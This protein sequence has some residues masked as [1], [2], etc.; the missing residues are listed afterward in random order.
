MLDRVVI[1]NSFLAALFLPDEDHAHATPLIER[2]GIIIELHAPQ[3]FLIEFSNLLT[4]CSRRKRIDQEELES[5]QR[6]AT[7]LPIQFHQN[8]SVTSIERQTRLALITGLSFYD[9]IYL[10]L[11]QSIGAS[12]A[13]LDKKLSEAARTAKVDLWP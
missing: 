11:A 12:L 8:V 5:A 2:T 7:S 13:T 9:T 3:F 6:L 1:D 4:V 10:D